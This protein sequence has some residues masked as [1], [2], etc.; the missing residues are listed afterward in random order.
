MSSN[1]HVC[2]RK[3]LIVLILL[4]SIIVPLT[5]AE[6]SFNTPLYRINGDVRETESG[7]KVVGSWRFFAKINNEGG[8][9]SDDK[10]HDWWSRDWSFDF[11]FTIETAQ[12]KRV[13]YRLRNF[14]YES[15]GGW[16]FWYGKGYGKHS[17][18]PYEFGA[19]GHIDIYSNG[20]LIEEQVPMHALLV[21]DSLDEPGHFTFEIDSEEINEL[22][23]GE[24]R[25]TVTRFQVMDFQVLK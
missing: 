5:T 8:W 12:G 20:Q 25:G 23:G 17:A 11:D 24:I 2:V 16:A 21:R 9:E 10:Q 3:A 6:P 4:F 15:V 13:H 19:T 14:H 7:V 18:G 1:N 22:T